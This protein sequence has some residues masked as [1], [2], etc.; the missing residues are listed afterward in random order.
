MGL[1]LFFVLGGSALPLFALASVAVL[2][3][4]QTAAAIATVAIALTTAVVIG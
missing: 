1:D 3:P 4:R 2:F